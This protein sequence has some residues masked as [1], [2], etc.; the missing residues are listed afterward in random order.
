MKTTNFIL[1]LILPIFSFSQ[2]FKL[3][4]DFTGKNTEKIV[5]RYIDLNGKP[6]SDT[7]KIESGKFQT[8]GKLSSVQ[9]VSI[10]GNTESNSMGDPNLGHFFMEPGTTE[11]KLKEDDFKNIVVNGSS[12]QKEYKLVENKTKPLFVKLDSISKNRTENSTD[13][14]EAGQEKIQKIELCYAIENPKSKL[15][16]Y[17]LKFYMRS[18]SVDSVDVIFNSFS[19]ENRNS[20]YGKEINELLDKK[21]VRVNDIAPDFNVRDIS[22]NMLSLESYKG[23]YLLI[24]FWADWC[25]PCIEKFP[26]VKLLIDEYGKKGLEVLFVSFDQTENDWKKGVK[27][28]NISKWDHIFIGNKNYKSKETISYKYDIQPIP[29]Y[30]LID[31]KG[32]VIGRYASASKENKDFDDLVKKLKVLMK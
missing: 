6:V 15:S 13:L 1:F 14:L 4:G 3:N 2:D 5:L 25:K 17:F 20:I 30:I 9:R 7:L 27:K 11:I 26:E 21:I 16:P 8:T 18:I 10:I 32:K 22:G 12:T 28:H 19:L 29:A 23:K 31:P 24:D